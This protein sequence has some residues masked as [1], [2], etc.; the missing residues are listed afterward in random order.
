MMSFNDR[1]SGGV[2]ARQLQQ[3]WDVYGADGEKVGDVSELHEGYFIAKQGL[4]FSHEHY[5]PF[6]A[7]S[8]V[9]HDRVYLA[10]TK[11]QIEAQG[12]DQ[13]PPHGSGVLPAAGR[14]RGQ[15]R[16]E[17]QDTMQLREEQLRVNKQQ[18]EAGE[19]EVRKEVV[20]EQQTLDVPVT[21]EE[22][23]IERHPVD[24]AEGEHRAAGEIGGGQTLRVPV[25]EE[26]VT[27][28][29]DTV[30]TEEIEVGKRQVQDTQRVADTV[31]REEAVI[32]REG[33]VDLDRGQ[34]RRR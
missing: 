33:D 23:V 4:I 26:Q 13:A 24:R 22:V 32:D 30:V 8:R 7:I 28:D 19:V 27:V 31:R 18:R 34:P 17:D 11:D 10:V 12:W 20:A 25:R 5:I 9:E 16:L 15:E 14:Q 29:K 2:T 6:S 3:G 21:H 1:T